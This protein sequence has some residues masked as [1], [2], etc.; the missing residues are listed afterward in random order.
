M[1]TLYC[2]KI[3]RFDRTAEPL[4]VSIPF[5]AGRIQNPQQL[6]IQSDGRSWPC[7][8]RALSRW[9]DGSVQWLLTHF[10][11][12]LPG[13]LD[14]TFTFEVSP[15][16]GA[17]YSG[18]QVLVHEKA[19]GIEVNTGRLRF[20]IGREGFLPVSQVQLDGQSVVLVPRPWAGL[21]WW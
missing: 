17:P 13:N 21:N 9:P 3:S 15:G 16:A 20:L 8:N 10:Q 4:T 7:Q 12:D 19:A 11:A 2:E 14:R 6:M 5:A 1:N 18:P